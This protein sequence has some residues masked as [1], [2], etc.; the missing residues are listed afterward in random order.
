MVPV[1]GHLGSVS[2]ENRERLLYALL[3]GAGPQARVAIGG[4]ADGKLRVRQVNDVV[5]PD[6]AEYGLLL[7][8][9]DAPRAVVRVDHKVPLDERPRLNFLRHLFLRSRLFRAGHP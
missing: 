8:P 9:G 6:L 7:Y 4:N 1:G 5:T 2:P 3:V